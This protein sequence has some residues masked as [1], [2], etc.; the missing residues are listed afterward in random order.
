MFN[1]I[2][3][4][5]LFICYYQCQLQSNLVFLSL[6]LQPPIQPLTS[7]FK[8]TTLDFVPQPSRISTLKTSVRFVQGPETTRGKRE[9]LASQ[10]NPKTTLYRILP[11]S[12]SRRCR[13]HSHPICIQRCEHELLSANDFYARTVL[14]LH[15]YYLSVI[16]NILSFMQQIKKQSNLC[17]IGSGQFLESCGIYA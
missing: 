11:H 3:I 16:F 12:Q 5:Q 8:R 6:K 9:F 15:Q 13:F 10:E 1:S 2:I 14:N 17:V 4:I 7:F